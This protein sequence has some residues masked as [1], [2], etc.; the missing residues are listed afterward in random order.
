MV[1]KLS[2]GGEFYGPKVKE[3][4]QKQ[5]EIQWFPFP[6][7]TMVLGE[8]QTIVL[9]QKSEKVNI[10]KELVHKMS[11]LLNTRISRGEKV[12]II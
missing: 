2:A 6:Y 10:S 7:F 5:M 9:L 11:L 1:V 4:I 8:S 12:N 3:I